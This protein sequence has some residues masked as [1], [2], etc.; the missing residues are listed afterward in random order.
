MVT[1]IIAAALVTAALA[2][3]IPARAAD[4]N[5]DAGAFDQ[6]TFTVRLWGWTQASYASRLTAVDMVALSCAVD[7]LD[8]WT[9]EV[10]GGMPFSMPLKSVDAFARGG[11]SRALL[12][13][14]R[15]GRGADGW[16]VKIPGLIGYRF[17]RLAEDVDG[18]EVAWSAHALTVSTG[19]DVVRWFGHNLGLD[20]RATVGGSFPVG[21]SLEGDREYAGEEPR[22]PMVDLGV[23]IGL[24]F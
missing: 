7:F 8:W 15:D 20:L 13:T 2:L 1:R 22:F 5:P 4:A 21:T 17:L 19:F 16:Q 14:R 10:G 9:V 12:D 18:Y 11:I 6:T 24:A 3:S 23:S